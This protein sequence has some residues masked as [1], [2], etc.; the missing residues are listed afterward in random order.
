MGTL[1]R[2]KE[3]VG[4]TGDILNKVRFFDKDIKT[5]VEVSATKM[6]KVLVSF[7]CRMETVLVDIWKIVSRSLVGES[8]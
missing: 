1:E 2:I 8:N 4:T 5:E 3:V 6:I 7:T